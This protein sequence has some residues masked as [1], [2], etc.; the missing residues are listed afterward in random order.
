MK[1]LKLKH[2]DIFKRM[3][4]GNHTK[5]T[6]TNKD[7]QIKNEKILDLQNDDILDEH[8]HDDNAIKSGQ[9]HSNKSDQNDAMQDDLD[10]D[11]I[12]FQKNYNVYDSSIPHKVIQPLHNDQN[13]A[14]KIDHKSKDSNKL[15]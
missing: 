6:N 9:I 15:M 10:D 1:Y 3:K 11:A 13:M 5:D 14:N 8:D 12:F 2:D 7:L 4:Q